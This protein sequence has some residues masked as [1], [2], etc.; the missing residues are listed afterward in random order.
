MC[1]IV[2]GLVMRSGRLSKSFIANTMLPLEIDHTVKAQSR[3]SSCIT[4][5]CSQSM[6]VVI[7]NSMFAAG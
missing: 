7:V 1:L 2:G 5:A 3:Y 4:A 6:I